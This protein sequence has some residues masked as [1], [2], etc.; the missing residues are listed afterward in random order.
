MKSVVVVSTLDFRRVR[1]DHME[2]TALLQHM[3]DI[4]SPFVF[5]G[6]LS[7]SF[8]LTLQVRAVVCPSMR[9]CNRA[10]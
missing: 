5:V 8:H 1:R 6:L 7:A 2:V 10:S 9:G 3:D 4:F